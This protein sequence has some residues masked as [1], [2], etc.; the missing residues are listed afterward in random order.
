MT[1]E[2]PDLEQRFDNAGLYSKAGRQSVLRGSLDMT[3]HGGACYWRVG[4]A[5][6]YLS[7]MAPAP[8]LQAKIDALIVAEI[9][10]P[11]WRARASTYCP[12]RGSKA[13][14]SDGVGA[15]A[16]AAV[17]DA[18]QQNADWLE[19]EV[20]AAQKYLDKRVKALAKARALLEAVKVV[21]EMPEAD[22]V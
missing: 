10:N 20:V 14:S 15:T 18:V 9:G 12:D 4:H 19:R 21:V 5:S 17:L 22:N 3:R 2:K 13:Y 6:V 11:V 16:D 8:E 7:G 1:T